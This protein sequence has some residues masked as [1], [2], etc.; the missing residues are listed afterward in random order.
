M[1]EDDDGSEED[2]SAYEDWN[3]AWNRWQLGWTYAAYATYYDEPNEDQP[4]FTLQ[5]IGAGFVFGVF[6]TGLLHIY[7]LKV[8]GI[9]I[10]PGAAMWPVELHSFHELRHMDPKHLLELGVPSPRE[11]LLY[12]M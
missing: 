7:I 12:M 3:L 1:L 10:A 2:L 9:V 11:A 4:R 5:D 6:L 8:G